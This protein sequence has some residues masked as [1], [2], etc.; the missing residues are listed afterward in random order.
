MPELFGHELSDF[1]LSGFA[2]IGMICCLVGV[3][4]R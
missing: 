1:W 4:A 2:A 3:T